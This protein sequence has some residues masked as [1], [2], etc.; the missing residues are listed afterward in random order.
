LPACKVLLS[1]MQTLEDYACRRGARKLTGDNLKP[2]WA[3]FSTL[4]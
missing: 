3:K 1:G 2:V 4:S